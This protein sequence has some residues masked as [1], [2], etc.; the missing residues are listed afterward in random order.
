MKNNIEYYRHS[1]VSDQHPK[2]KMLRNKYGWEGEGKFWALNNRIAQAENCCLNITKKYNKASIATDL[3]FKIEEFDEYI[4]FLIIDCELVNE[5]EEGLTTDTI[6]ENFLNVS[7]KRM[8]NK[9]GYQNRQK[10]GSSADLS[11]G[12]PDESIIQPDDLE[13][14]PDELTQS[15]VKES[16][17]KESKVNKKAQNEI[18]SSVLNDLNTRLNLKKGFSCKTTNNSSKIIARLNEGYKLEDFILVNQKKCKQWIDDPEMAQYLR[19]ETLYSNKFEGYLNQIEVKTVKQVNP[20]YQTAD[21]RRRENNKKV[22]EQSIQ[23]IDNVYGTGGNASSKGV[24]GTEAQ[25]NSGFFSQLRRELPEGNDS[26]TEPDL[27]RKSESS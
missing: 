10:S 5:T 19:P 11:S 18:V 2:F 8:R 4:L 17:V 20:K 16:K 1:V 12:D 15:K 6:Q 13:I 9:I 14:Q 26:R 27:D 7:E 22:F 21:E 23:E 25:G 3:G 24:V